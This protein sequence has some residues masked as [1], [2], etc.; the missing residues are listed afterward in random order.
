M[1][2]FCDECGKKIPKAR[3]NALP[4]TTLCVSCA[5]EMEDKLGI[6]SKFS[7]DDLYDYTDLR[8]SVISDD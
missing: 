4:N 1:T 7:E 5:A 6:E 8:D 3:L 2:V